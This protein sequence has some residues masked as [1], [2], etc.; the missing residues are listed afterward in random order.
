MYAWMPVVFWYKTLKVTKSFMSVRDPL[1]G[2]A[3]QPTREIAADGRK[4][5]ECCSSS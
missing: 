2:E 4:W 5:G 1:R 3:P